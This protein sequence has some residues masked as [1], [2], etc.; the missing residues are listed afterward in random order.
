MTGV[1]LEREIRPK[2]AGESHRQM[3][4]RTDVIRLIRSRDHGIETISTG[5]AL[6]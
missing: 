4:E 3:E 1:S 6:R 5:Q 2:E